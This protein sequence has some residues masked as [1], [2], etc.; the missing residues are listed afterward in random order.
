MKCIYIHLIDP[1]AKYPSCAT[2]MRINDNKEGYYNIHHGNMLDS[3]EAE[4]KVIEGITYAIIHHNS[5]KTELVD[6]YDAP[7]SFR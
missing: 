6:G 3:I 2:A 7:G 1:S 4:C 5:E